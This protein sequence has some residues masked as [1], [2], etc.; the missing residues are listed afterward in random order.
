MKFILALF[1]VSS[2]SYAAPVNELSIDDLT[3][4]MR[5]TYEN[6]AT[7][8]QSA[9]IHNNYNLNYW[10]VNCGTNKSFD[11]K[12]LV[13]RWNNYPYLSFQVEFNIVERRTPVMNGSSSSTW[14]HFSQQTY[15]QGVD[16]S[17]D[18]ENGSGVLRLTIR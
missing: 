14:L 16:L 10:S 6:K 15:L 11:V 9:C 3:T 7:G 2:I 17:Q 1:L 12:V 5:F 4:M 8:S 18:C 13:K